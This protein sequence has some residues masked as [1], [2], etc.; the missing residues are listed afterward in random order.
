MEEC[1]GMLAGIE[2][3]NNTNYIYWKSCLESYLQSQDLWEIVNGNDTE[4]P[5]EGAD[6]LRKWKIRAGKAL[7]VLKASIQKEL[8]EHIRDVKTP[9]EAWEAL[10]SLSFHGRTMNDEESEISESHMRRMIIRGLRPEFSCFITAIRGWPMQPSLL[11]L[12]N[13]LINQEMLARQMAGL[14]V[15][16][17]EEALA[18][19]SK[20]KWKKKNKKPKDGYKR[21]DWANNNEKSQEKR[22]F[23]YYHCGKLGYIRRNCRARSETDDGNSI[24]KSKDKDDDDDDGE[25][26]MQ[27][28][29][30]CDL[31]VEE[32]AM[33]FDFAGEIYFA[34]NVAESPIVKSH[35]CAINSSGKKTIDYEN[36]WLID[37][38][39]SHHM[40]GNQNKFM[41]LRK[42]DGNHAAVTVDN[43]V[44]AM[45]DVGD[46]TVTSRCGEGNSILKDV[47]HVPGM[48]KNLVSVAQIT[49]AG[50]YVLFGPNDV[51]VFEKVN[52]S[53]NLIMRGKRMET[54]YVLSAGT[55]YVDK[56]RR[57]ET[58]EL[59]HARLAHVA[60]DKSKIM[61]RRNLVRGLPLLENGRDTQK[62]VSGNRYF[63]ILVGDFSGY[64][65]V[66]FLQE[67]SEVFEKINDFHARVEA[68][69]RF[70]I[71]C[72]RTDNGKEYT[73]QILSTYL[74]DQYKIKRQFTCHE[75]PQQ[76]GVAERKNRHLVETC[77][78]VLHGRNV[79]PQYWAECIR[80]AIYQ[81]RTKVVKTAVRAMFIG[82]DEQMKGLRCLVPC[83]KRVCVS[84]DVV[85]DEASS[86]W[87]V[88]NTTMPDSTDLI[89]NLKERLNLIVLRLENH[90]VANPNSI[91]KMKSTVD[92]SQMDGD[93]LESEQEVTRQSLTTTP[94]NG[95]ST[96]KS[97]SPWKTGKSLS[98]EKDV[99]ASPEEL[100][101]SPLEYFEKREFSAFKPQRSTR[102]PKANP[103]YANL[104]CFFKMEDSTFF[105]DTKCVKEW[106]I[107]RLR[108]FSR[109]E[110]SVA[111]GELTLKGSARVADSCTASEGSGR[112]G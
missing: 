35:V 103:K 94:Q 104:A 42:Y 52:V 37:S 6:T 91:Q 25:W 31:A 67:K 85:F 101:P 102:I 80:A 13:L 49:S 17:S 98:H 74:R 56:A 33:E 72:L 45:K 48:A 51:K 62:S 70:K 109:K 105:E 87:S 9:K 26:D 75:T 54:M 46:V 58:P 83:T 32:T 59:W 2:K 27:A 60:Y 61:A 78:S 1:L 16:E 18:V 76:N 41:R 15:K 14:S 97:S 69:T 30:A 99:P 19:N 40:T 93:V 106:Q 95:S 65:W 43:S 7:Y 11:E 81:M 110:L 44:H 22:D 89:G 79:R 23:Y 64:V 108:K 53:D 88:E 90:G 86:W 34:L 29:F 12:E 55:A 20:Q 28:S 4:V 71:G 68:E 47:Y 57:N 50:I 5:E 24:I 112:R 10:S 73:S 82:Y 96:S 107:D 3:L 84:R 38:G 39:C 66:Y 92:L 21:D 111:C 100:R 8:I 77:R 63:R 36:D